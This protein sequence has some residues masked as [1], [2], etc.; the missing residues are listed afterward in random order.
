MLKNYFKIAIAVLKRKKF[1]SFIS[2]FGISFTLAVLMIITAF[3]DHVVGT[4]YP[5]PNAGRCLYLLTTSFTST[6]NRNQMNTSPSYDY[7][8]KY[9]KSLKTPEKVSIS[10]FAR[11]VSS[12]LNNK[13]YTFKLQNTDAEF[14]SVTGFKFIEGKPFDNSQIKNSENV[15]VINEDSRKI[16]FGDQSAVGKTF[17]T[18][19]VSYKVIGVVK[20]VAITKFFTDADLYAPYT[21][22][23]SGYDVKGL[24][25]SYKAIVLA[26][27]R[28]D[29]SAIDA[30]YQQNV[31]KIPIDDRG[32]D[33][34]TSHLDSFLEC[35]IRP[36]LGNNNSSGI[37]KF[38]MIIGILIFIFLLLP[39]VNLVNIN[40]SRI[41]ERSSEIGVR[42]SFGAA[43]T[44]LVMQ[45]I[46]ENLILTLIGGCIGLAIT[47][48]TI[49]YIN[50]S[51]WI[52]AVDLK[53]NFTVLKFGLLL[54]IFFGILS[55]VYPAFKMSKLQIIKS[56][57]SAS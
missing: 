9:V 31:K 4:S 3:V 55:G 8:N 43:R 17:V 30:E 54:C 44:T 1:F 36:G 21:S 15:I 56:L 57:K 7:L 41:L 18:D 6:K 2:L 52:P 50:A 19:G 47:F 53:V 13:K 40:I 39:T 16:Y 32:F 35:I 49:W 14:W 22:P 29:F 33:K 11:P 10:S 48:L 27:Q 26:K 51:G 37:G 45:F 28:S 23:K 46:V 42:K 38:Y 20:S 24:H 34:L 12:F 5:E 25:G